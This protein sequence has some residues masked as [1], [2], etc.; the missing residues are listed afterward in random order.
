MESN[1]IKRERVQVEKTC[2]AA[3]PARNADDCCAARAP[4]VQAV[5]SGGQ[6]HAIE[7]TC[8]CG[9]VML[10]ELDYEETSREAQR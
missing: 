7:V 9:E 4:K 6:V 10:V 1:I 2:A 5:S 3:A 8:A